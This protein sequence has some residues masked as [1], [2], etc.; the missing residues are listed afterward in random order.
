MS[1]S[2]TGTRKTNKTQKVKEH[3]LQYG[4]ITSIEAI[5]L[6]GATRLSAII[7]NLRHRDNMPIDSIEKRCEDKYGNVGTYAKYVLL[8]GI[9]AA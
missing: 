9:I 2:N 6:Y 7:F 1:K 8:P 3:L 4:S 5:D